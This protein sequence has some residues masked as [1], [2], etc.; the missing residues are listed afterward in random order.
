MFLL[1]AVFLAVGCSAQT[2]TPEAT[3]E[4]ISPE[5]LGIVS[6]TAEVIPAQWA[7]LSFPIGG[8]LVEVAVEE[9][10]AVQ[11]GDL[12]ARLDITDLDI[13]LARAEASLGVA[14]ANLALA[15]AG[16]R[17]EEVEEARDRLSAANARVAAAVAERDRLQAPP[18]PNQ[19]LS[20][21]AQVE[22]AAMN[23]ANIQESYDELMA[24]LPNWDQYDFEPGDR[25]PLDGEQD[26]RNAVE[27]AQLQLAAA[28]ANL[29]RL[30]AG[31]RPGEI[32]VA[33]A[34]IWLAA[35]QRDA[36]QA[37]LDLLLAGPAPT[38]IAVAEAEVAQARAAVE[39]AEAERDQ[40]L[41][42]A[43]FDGTI[44]EILAD[45]GEFIGPGQV[46]MVV[47]DLNNLRVETTDLN[48][49]D[50][51]RVQVGN[52]ATVTFDALPDE[53]IQG[54]VVQIAPKS[55]EGA[56]VNYTVIVEL[57]EVPAALMWGMTAFVDIE[58]E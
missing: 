16:P 9:G 34:R 33:N 17:D 23:A 46:V 45:E 7:S 6:A 44:S 11:S 49:L 47:G 40:G 15:Q 51:A 22:Q 42:V 31:P 29:D 26:L 50:V 36:A 1:L 24:F 2:A 43:P 41:L 38:D 25:T 32:E 57:D 53:S 48:E 52:S 5:A 3:E 39:A 18:D 10:M 14:E 56:G 30:L 58:T 54:T 27:L 28:Q 21:Q 19:V 13:A 20:A 35:A 8:Q 12:I 4:A 55:S 37:Y